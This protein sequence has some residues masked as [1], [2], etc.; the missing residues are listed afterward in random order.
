MDIESAMNSL[1]NAEKSYDYAC[2]EIDKLRAII[3]KKDEALK[4]YANHHNW[5]HIEKNGHTFAC[6]SPADRVPDMPN[7]VGGLLA[8]GGKTAIEALK[9]KS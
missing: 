7:H 6:I 5:I 2:N 1:E 8:T 4:F 3:S 9:V